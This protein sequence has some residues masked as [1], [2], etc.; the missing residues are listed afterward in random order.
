MP[1]PS[2]DTEPQDMNDSSPAASSVL[3]S[4]SLFE[5]S[6]AYK[7]GRKKATRDKSNRHRGDT[8]AYYTG[9]DDSSS[10]SDGIRRSQCLAVPDGN[11]VALHV[12]E[13]G[14]RR[15]SYDT[16][17]LL[18]SIETVAQSDMLMDPSMA[19]STSS[20][21]KSI[22]RM[23]PAQTQGDPSSWHRQTSDCQRDIARN[24]A[25]VYNSFPTTNTLESGESAIPSNVAAPSATSSGKGFA[26]PL[27][28]CGRLFK[29]LEHLKRH[30]RT[31]TQERPFECNR[32]SKRFSRSDNLTQHI[33][34]HE[35]AEQR[36]ERMKTEASEGG[37]VHSI[38]Y[39]DGELDLLASRDT[40]S[41][42]GLGSYA[43]HTS[44][45]QGI[46][47]GKSIADGSCD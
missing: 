46:S 7:Q 40:Q 35:K 34:T 26:C 16:N 29:R 25:A 42:H 30:V 3:F 27:L 36:G 24:P 19:S 38:P 32:C 18:A 41:F 11:D 1:S 6:P 4:R 28:S 39:M 43:S 44:E 9:E 33:K 31:H 20:S 8:G 13:P 37:E 12:G 23:T 47:N 22:D 14:D 21:P 2:S 17:R 10:T 15:Q 5:G 45:C